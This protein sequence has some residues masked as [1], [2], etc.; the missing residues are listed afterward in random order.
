MLNRSHEELLKECIEERLR[1]D[2]LEAV[3]MRLEE[4]L[5]HLTDFF[6]GLP[7]VAYR[8][9]VDAQLSMTFDSFV[10]GAPDLIGHAVEDFIGRGVQT[11]EQFVDGRDLPAV[12]HEVRQAILE[13][14]PYDI[15]YRVAGAAEGESGWIWDKGKPVC[16]ESGMP[17]ALNGVLV[18]VT[19]WMHA[20][21]RLELENMRLRA[22][23][24]ESC[25][26]GGLYGCSAV[27][28]HVYEQIVKCAE[29]G[30][31][32]VIYGE[33]GTGKTLTART[34]H[35][36]SARE[37]RFVVVDCEALSMRECKSAIFGTASLRGGLADAE[38]GTLYIR[39]MD[40]LDT[41]LQLL[42]LQALKPN[43]DGQAGADVRIMASCRQ[44]ARELVR[45][46]VLLQK[47]FY[48]VHVLTLT[49]PPL[50]FRK[51]DIP[52][53]MTHFASRLCCAGERHPLP[54]AIRLALEEYDWPGNVRELKNVVEQYLAVGE[55]H[56]ADLC[57]REEAALVE[58]VDSGVSMSMDS[59]GE[60]TMKDAVG[61]LERAMILKALVECSG[62]RSRAAEK[63]GLNIRTMQRKVRR[64]GL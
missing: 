63:L 55:V 19:D 7:C 54:A 34:V 25:R 21:Q 16:N 4:Q 41:G 45:Q 50:R 12:L 31:N 5:G 23:V 59:V 61:R 47:F 64:Y 32:L 36:L 57:L 49:V 14:R 58:A 33:A 1:A 17:V 8:C 3:N 20:R 28:R 2:K 11:F 44:D 52:L 29:S 30:V 13:Q 18:D 9:A 43:E 24:G 40:K 53:L 56:L 46:G 10:E 35:D 26:L 42:L 22:A 6:Q 39:N 48:R 37:G 62:S 51:D 38:G 60:C 15:V 27:M